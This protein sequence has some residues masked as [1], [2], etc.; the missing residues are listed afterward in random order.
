[1]GEPKFDQLD[2]GDVQIT[3]PLLN[4][5]EPLIGYVSSWHL[6]EPKVIQM[7]QAYIG[8]QS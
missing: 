4:G 6:I 7:R 3:I 1:M 8:S 2:S 5:K